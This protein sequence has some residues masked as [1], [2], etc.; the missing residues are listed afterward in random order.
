M[1]MKIKIF[2]DL[3]R[4]VKRQIKIEITEIQKILIRTNQK[5]M[6]KMKTFLDLIKILKIKK[7]TIGEIIM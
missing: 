5:K 2:S 6:K 4:K 3:I 1:E 7:M